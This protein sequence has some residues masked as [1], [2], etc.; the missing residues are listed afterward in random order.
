MTASGARANAL[1]VALVGLLPLSSGYGSWRGWRS[2]DGPCSS[3]TVGLSWKLCIRW[4]LSTH[5]RCFLSVG[6]KVSTLITGYRWAAS[7]I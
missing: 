5:M 3:P 7:T 1:V 4:K 2:A 6:C